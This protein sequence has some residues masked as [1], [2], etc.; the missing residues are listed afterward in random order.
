[1]SQPNDASLEAAD[2]I[3]SALDELDAEE[4]EASST[5]EQAH[6]DEGGEKADAKSKDKSDE[7]DDESDEDDDESEDEK[8]GKDAKPRN[9]KT[10]GKRIS[11][12]TRK[13]N[14][15][16]R[17]RESLEADRK[18][19]AEELEALRRF[20]QEAMRRSPD[21]ERQPTSDEYEEGRKQGYTREQVEELVQKGVQ[22]QRQQEI[23]GEKRDTLKQKLVE[24]GAQSALDRLSNARLVEFQ[25]E[26][27]LTLSEA[28]HPVAVAKALAQNEDLFKQLS[29]TSDPVRQSRLIERI[30]SRIETRRQIQKEGAGQSVKPTRGVRGSTKPPEK[31]PDDMDQAEYE[32]YRAKQGW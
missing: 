15:E 19:D 3:D 7:T 9:K 2:P 21:E 32:A 18:A 20:R 23:F 22:A 17:I 25:P 8:E 14:D 30:D 29:E 31:H 13:Y 6:D 11:E 27:L 4:S 1:M 24:G 26:A 5:A 28:K 16:R 10:A 12:L